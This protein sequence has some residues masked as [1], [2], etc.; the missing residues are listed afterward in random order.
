[1]QKISLFE[2]VLSGHENKIQ[3]E[4]IHDQL[5]SASDV[6]NTAEEYEGKN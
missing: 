2:L 4:H 1:M 6:V 5:K 3:P